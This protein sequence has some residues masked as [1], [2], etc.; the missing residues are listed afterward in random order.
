[1]PIGEEEILISFDVDF[2]LTVDSLA[3][4]DKGPPNNGDQ[5]GI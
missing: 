3:P 2:R 1:M 5:G 4:F